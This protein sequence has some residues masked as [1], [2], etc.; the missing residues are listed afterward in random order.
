MHARRRDRT[1]RGFTLAE[2][3]VAI[4]IAAVA[5]AALALGMTSS[6][7]ATNAAVEQ[8]IA[9]GLAEQLMDEVVGA[10]YSA[11]GAGGRQ[12]S[13]GPSSWESQGPGRSRFDDVDDY[14]NRS[15]QPPEDP[16]GITLG[17]DD[18]RGGQRHP[19]FQAPDGYLNRWRREV[20]VYYVRGTDF[21]PLPS[22]QTSDY[23]AV[24]VRVLHVNPNGG[25]RELARLQRVVAYV[26]PL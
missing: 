11:V 4:A 14:A 24:E 18:G 15:A 25:A 16:W 12:T 9:T 3:V 6:L 7:Q 10:R 17:T 13:L 21:T 5:G 23:R 19:G 1:H 22:G 26:E 8:A 20:R 2:A